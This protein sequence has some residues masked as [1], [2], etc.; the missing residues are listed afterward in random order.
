[1]TTLVEDDKKELEVSKFFCAGVEPREKKMFLSLTPGG[2]ERGRLVLRESVR[3]LDK[4]KTG[5]GTLT[6]NI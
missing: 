1:M 3:S 6:M 5:N 4:V 2:K